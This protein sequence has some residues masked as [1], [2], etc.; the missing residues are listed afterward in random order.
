[1]VEIK[2]LGT[3]CGVPICVRHYKVAP[4]STV[5]NA[6]CTEDGYVFDKEILNDMRIEAKEIRH[7][8]AENL[9]KTAELFGVK[10]YDISIS[11]P[12]QTDGSMFLTIFTPQRES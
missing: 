9:I 12:D 2:R 6:V 3:L 7:F 11:G 1:M 4:N 8:L 5:I 10:P